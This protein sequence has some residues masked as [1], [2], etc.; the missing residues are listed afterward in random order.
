VSSRPEVSVIIPTRDRPRLVRQ[1]IR[2]ALGQRDVSLEVIVVNDGEAEVAESDDPRM[3]VLRNRSNRG[4]GGARNCGIEAARGEWIAPLDDDDLWAPHKLRIQL[5]AAAGSGAPWA[6]AGAVVVEDVGGDL[7]I[8]SASHAPTPNDLLDEIAT[9]NIVPA[10]GSNVIFRRDAIGS[11]MPYDESLARAQDWDLFLRLARAGRPAAVDI[12]SVAYRLHSANQSL[13]TAE[14][15]R[16]IEVISARGSDLRGDR[17]FDWARIHR[18]IAFGHLRT[19]HRVAAMKAYANA[20]RAGDLSSLARVPIA[21]MPRGLARRAIVMRQ[22]DEW[23]ASAR[24][25]IDELVR[26]SREST[27][28][29][30]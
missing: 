21:L 15:L 13:R 25:W 4:S 2:S 5:A 23:S 8:L 18:W 10:G 20:V 12:P 11:V 1:A 24:G 29:Q 22:S 17:P 6:Y 28:R 9:R 26:A 30:L 16:C 7:R 14:T 27:E 19:G 3:R